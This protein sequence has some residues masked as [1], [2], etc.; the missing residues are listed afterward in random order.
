M[1]H[2]LLF[3]IFFTSSYYFSQNHWNFNYQ[4]IAHNSD[5]DTISN[6]SFEVTV[7][8]YSDTLD[9]PNYEETHNVL[10]NNFGL[11]YFQI[12][13]GN[14]TSSSL[15]TDLDW[16]DENLNYFVNVNIYYNNQYNDLGYSPLVA[17][18]YAMSSKFSS[19]SQIVNGKTVESN[20]PSNAIFTDSQQIELFQYDSTNQSITLQIEN[21]NSRIIYLSSFGLTGPTGSDGIQ[22]PT[23]L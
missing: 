19:E 4:A 3:L 21:N 7:G 10:T 14:T 17:V 23:G 8:I 18:P 9:S 20:V 13:N 1:K 5:G 2:L 12:G 22:G 15:I 11:F 6:D 16:N